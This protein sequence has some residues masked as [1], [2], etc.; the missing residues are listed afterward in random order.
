[1]N[2]PDGRK[3][4]EFIRGDI[5]PPYCVDLG[6]SIRYSV[7]ITQSIANTSPAGIN[8]DDAVRPLCVIASGGL[9][10]VYHE[11]PKSIQI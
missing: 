1:M 10:R 4:P 2:Y 5:S 8:S 3:T 7:F 9:Q 6:N 11:N